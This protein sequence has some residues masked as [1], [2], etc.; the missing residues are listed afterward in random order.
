MKHIKRIE[1]EK[2]NGHLGTFNY[3]VTLY[4]SDKFGEFI[5]DTEECINQE[6]VDRFLNKY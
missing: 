5:I 2:D 3:F 6:E 1:I 4:G